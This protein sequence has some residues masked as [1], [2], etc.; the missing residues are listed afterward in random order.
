M[1]YRVKIKIKLKKG[2][3]DPEAL[4]IKKGLSLLGYDVENTRTANLIYFEMNGKD[5]KSVVDSV[6]DMCK[7]LLCNPVIHDYK[8]DVKRIS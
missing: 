2:M 1:K 7:R 4:A 3:L 5:K 8:I 6:E